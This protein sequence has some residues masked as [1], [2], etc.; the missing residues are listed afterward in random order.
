M[1]KLLLVLT[2]ISTGC[3]AQG[4]AYVYSANGDLQGTVVTFSTQP[5]T[6]YNPNPA[7]R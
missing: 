3:L 1:K 4:I 5:A 7:G 6:I 2:L